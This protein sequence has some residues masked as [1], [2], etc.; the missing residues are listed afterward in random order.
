MLPLSAK[1]PARPSD[2]GNKPVSSTDQNIDL[3]ILSAAKDLLL[4][5]LVFPTGPAALDT[6]ERP[7]NVS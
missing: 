2:V 7:L 4:L 1:R 6:L 5:L 3:V